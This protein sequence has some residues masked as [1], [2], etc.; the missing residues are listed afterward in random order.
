MRRS[1]RHVTFLTFLAVTAPVLAAS[2]SP[3]D[4]WERNHR[5]LDRWREEDPGHYARLQRDLRAFWS[6]PAERQERLRK[7]DRDLNEADSA[8]RK[9]LWGVLERYTLWLERLPETDRQ[10]IEAAANRKERLE[11]IHQILERQALDRLPR[12]AREE[13]LKLKEDQRRA[14][15]ARLRKEERHLRAEWKLALKGRPGPGVPVAKPARLVDF[16]TDVQAFVSTVLKPQLSHEET[17]RLTKAEGKWP[18]FACL[19]F[20]LAEKYPLKLPG[21]PKGPVNFMDLPPNVRQAMPF[22][23]LNPNQ[24]KHLMSIMGKWPDF[25]IEFTALAH[26]KEIALPRQLGPCAPKDFTPSLEPFID[27]VLVPKLSAKE[28]DS[29]D[30]AKGKWPDY[31]RLLLELS[32]KHNLE[33]PGMKLPGPRDL[34]ERARA[35][36]PKD[37]AGGK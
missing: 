32:K 30:S 25:A 10:R 7:L 23:S 26:R 8:A 33:V 35:E 20:D 12:K 28:K 2:D 13:L 22:A 19:L 36:L 27:K 18:Q 9:K 11:I 6:L 5:L 15:L 14:E 21:P 4:E 3:P 37:G 17:E 24:K 34:W 31:P 1:W 16:P 29:L